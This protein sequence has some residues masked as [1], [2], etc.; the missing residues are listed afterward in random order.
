MTITNTDLFKPSFCEIGEGNL[1][2]DISIV[3]V[4]PSHKIPIYVKV[5]RGEHSIIG[6]LKKMVKH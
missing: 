1:G 5:W 4:V 6:L 2:R 3:I